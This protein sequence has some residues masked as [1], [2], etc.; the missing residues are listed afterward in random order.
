MLL[1]SNALSQHTSSNRPIGMVQMLRTVLVEDDIFYDPKNSPPRLYLSGQMIRH[2][3]DIA[4]LNAYNCQ[5]T[6]GFI[7]AYFLLYFCVTG[8]TWD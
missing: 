2:T 1:G 4:K 5:Y 6:D 3:G 8:N 7:R